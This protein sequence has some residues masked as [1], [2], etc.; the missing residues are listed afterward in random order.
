MQYQGLITD[1]GGVVSTNFELALYGFCAREGI[2]PRAFAAVFHI[3]AGSR[4]LLPQ[5]ERGEISQA[6]FVDYLAPLLGVRAPGLLERMCADL[7]LEPLVNTEIARLRDAGIRV[8][9]LSNSVGSHPF[10]PYA[11]YHLP[12]NFDAVVI[13]DQVGMRK[14]EPEIFQLTADKLGLPPSAC[15][16]VD[17]VSGYLPAAAALGMGT[18]HARQPDSTV[19]ELGRVFGI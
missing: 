12:E 10:D 8:A 18:I 6:E 11:A 9:V 17:D 13:S 7:E 15:V 4:G 2:D 3:E 14:P 19:A 5:L 1:F 16:F